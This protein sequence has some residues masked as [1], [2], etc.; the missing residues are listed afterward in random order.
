MRKSKKEITEIAEIESV[1]NKADVCRIALTDGNI[2]YIVTMN[3][4]Y[5]G[6][7]KKKLFF[8][9][10]REGK[11]L[12]MIRKNNYVCFEMDTDHELITGLR[13]CD[14][15][16][17]YR[18]VVGYGYVTVID[19]ENEKIKGLDCIMAHYSAG[20]NFTYKPETVGKTFVLSLEI[21]QITGK[22]C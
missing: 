14:F 12:D 21:S 22:R 17:K 7:E 16:M 20:K 11:K 9:C 5:S 4:G 15:T 19:D 3:F 18:S 6:G 8:H 2:P 13:G 10:A 1:I